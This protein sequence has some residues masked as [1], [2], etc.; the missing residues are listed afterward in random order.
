MFAPPVVSSSQP[1]IANIDGHWRLT[2]LLT[3]GPVELVEVRA[4]WLGH[5]T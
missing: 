5:P 1:E 3:S 4:N 2:W